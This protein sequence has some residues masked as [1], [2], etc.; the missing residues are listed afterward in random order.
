MAVETGPFMAFPACMLWSLRDILKEETDDP[1]KVLYEVGQRTG[2]ILGDSTGEKLDNVAFLDFIYNH[3]MENGLG[4][5]V[6]KMD[7]EDVIMTVEE[8]SEAMT[9]QG[10]CPFSCG[11]FSGI[12]TS[13][14]G[15]DYTCIEECCANGGE[16]TCVMRLSKK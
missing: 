5:P 11:Y 12:A 7:G 6:V 14:L 9:K 1:E 3:W 10:S 2:R 4:R 16:G 15:T 13:L 8:S